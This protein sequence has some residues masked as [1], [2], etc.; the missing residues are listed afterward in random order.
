[1]VL[2][3]LTD[4]LVAIERNSLCLTSVHNVY[5]WFGNFAWECACTGLL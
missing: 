2:I 5:C 4:V 3:Y 1:M